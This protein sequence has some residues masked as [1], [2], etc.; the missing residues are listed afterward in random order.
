LLPKFN[1]RLIR[2]CDFRTCRAVDYLLAPESRTGLI[3]AG[4]D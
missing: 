4:K 3:A 1:L 2:V